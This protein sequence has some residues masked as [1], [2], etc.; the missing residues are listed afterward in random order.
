MKQPEKLQVAQP[1]ECNVQLSPP[2]VATTHATGMQQASLK[3]LARKALAC[4]NPCNKSATSTPEAVQLS[5]NKTGE[6]VA[7]ELRQVRDRLLTLAQGIGV[8]DAIVT[9]LP[10]CELQATHDQLPL[11]PDADLQR[12][13]LLF[14]LKSLAGMEPALPGSLSARP[15]NPTRGTTT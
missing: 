9:N 6:K 8:P 3:A 2:S 11:W 13:V 14:Y 15:P 4:N 12:K 10:A 7:Q 1:R 5:C